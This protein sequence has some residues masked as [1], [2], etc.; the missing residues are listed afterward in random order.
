MCGGKHQILDSGEILENVP[1]LE[2]FLKI[3]HNRKV[4]RRTLNDSTNQRGWLAWVQPQIGKAI[5][6]DI[7]G[8][9]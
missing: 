7:H 6:D 1:C 5:E 2:P 4:V 3:P 8:H 9:P